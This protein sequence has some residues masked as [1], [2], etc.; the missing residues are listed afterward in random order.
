MQNF[1]IAV[2]GGGASGLA[3]AI[4]AA[5]TN[6]ELKI[7]VLERLPRIGKKILATGNGRC[8]YTN[9]NI[10]IS[11]YHGSCTA[12]CNSVKNFSCEDF[13]ESLGVYGYRD[14]EL[15][16]Y[17]L[18]NNAS[19]VLDSMR[20]EIVKL[21]I[22]VICDFNVT[23]IKKEKNYRIFS[24]NSCISA[25]SVIAAGG[26]MSQANLGSDGSVLRIL[27]KIG[28]K[29]SPLSPALTSFKV[30]PETVRSLKGIRANAAVT[31]FSDNGKLGSQR[32]EVQFG[33]G[34]ISGI[35][36]FN[37]SCL[38]GGKQNLELSIDMLPEMNF[39]EVKSLLLSIKK[40]RYNA[41]SEDFLSGILN[42]RIGMSIIKL[43]TDRP[44]T[45]KVS[46]VS[47]KELSKIAG[48]IKDYRFKVIGLSGFE[49]SQVTAGGVSA[50][51]V[52]DS[53]RSKKF[54]G[55]YFCGEILDIIGDC[56]GYNLHFAFA[57][58]AH[59]GK[60]CAEDLNDKNK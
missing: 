54:S 12:L 10:D 34:T 53:L 44:L 3:A 14:D 57:S 1:D 36:V 33:D 11:N 19:A 2:I 48:M 20:L 59:A 26:G 27:K 39:S 47:D 42:K 28:V 25:S 16:V 23:E 58:G 37:L 40:I 55:M 29:L 18:S 6:P 51:E 31:L 35:C 4:S 22:E 13:F 43:C 56:G 45:E 30:S 60:I 49:K 50:S 41:A 8:N 32:G 5:R 24:E 38:A 21:G 9:A 7:A 15:R 52:D 46:A 17:P